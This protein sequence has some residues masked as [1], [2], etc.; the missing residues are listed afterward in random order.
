M[1]VDISRPSVGCDAFGNRQSG[2]LG[3]VPNRSMKQQ[4][5]GKPKGQMNQHAQVGQ[6]PVQNLLFKTELCRSF[7]ESGHCPYGHKCQFAHGEAELRPTLKHPKFRTKLCRKFALYGTCPYGN[8]CTFRHSFDPPS[9]VNRFAMRCG[10]VNRN[11]E[12]R[13]SAMSQQHHHQQQQQQQQQQMQQQQQ[14]QQQ[15]QASSF[16]EIG[17]LTKKNVFGGNNTTRVS[18]YGMNDRMVGLTNEYERPQRLARDGAVNPLAYTLH[19]GGSNSTTGPSSS[20]FNGGAFGSSTNND[21]AVSPILSPFPICPRTIPRSPAN[22]G[23]N[24]I[25]SPSS[26]SP[27]PPPPPTLFT[28][29][30]AVSMDALLKTND[31][32]GGKS[33]K[34]LNVS[35][36]F[37]P[38]RKQERSEKDLDMN[39]TGVNNNNNNNNIGIGAS[40]VFAPVVG[41]A[42]S[43][44]ALELSRPSFT[45]AGNSGRKVNNWN[46]WSD[47]AGIPEKDSQLQ[48]L[49]EQVETLQKQLEATKLGGNE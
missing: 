44:Q 10:Y 3:P 45:Y 8:R 42:P 9:N 43:Q 22:N 30:L 19:S 21:R 40:S 28:Q 35:S 2:T 33:D 6:G 34:M 41:S 36:A 15:Q 1:V 46:M 32:V 29:D 27:P 11:Q 12:Q 38:F 39:N 18:Y 25:T 5:F 7:L 16:G 14:Q 20:L 49:Q 31:V 37:G 23:L 24:R 17:S 48:K 26:S 47:L 13:V 4:L